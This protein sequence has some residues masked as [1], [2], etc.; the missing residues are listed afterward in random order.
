MEPLIREDGLFDDG[1][2]SGRLYSIA[3]EFDNGKEILEVM[4]NGEPHVKLAIEKIDYMTSEFKDQGEFLTYLNK[5]CGLNSMPKKIYLEYQNNGEIKTADLIFD[6]V[7]I[8]QASDSIINQKRIKKMKKDNGTYNPNEYQYGIKIEDVGQIKASIKRIVGCIRVRDCFFD[9][10]RPASVFPGFYKKQIKREAQVLLSNFRTPNQEY[11]MTK[12]MSDMERD[13]TYYTNYRR[14]F[15]WAIG[16]VAKNRKNDEE[17]EQI[18]LE[19]V[20]MEIGQQVPDK[21]EQIENDLLI[22]QEVEEYDEYDES[23]AIEKT[24]SQRS[25]EPNMGPEDMIENSTLKEYYIKYDGDL[26][27]ILEILGEDFLDSVSELD[28]YRCGYTDY[29]GRQR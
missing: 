16:Y 14:A 4:Q 7:L 11:E 5:K 27:L 24:I 18:T 26:E 10:I 25:F 22:N 28:K 20:G 23:E 21:I 15:L 17:Y 3:I 29:V 6:S 9:I 12:L 19:D 13:L 1:L 8:R 2:T